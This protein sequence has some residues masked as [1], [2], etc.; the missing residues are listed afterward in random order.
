MVKLGRFIVVEGLEGAGKSTVVN[1]MMQYLKQH[2]IPTLSTR[3]PGG[4]KIGEALRQLIKHGLEGE[5]LV[6]RAELLL[7]YAARVQLVETTIR[8][9]L[10]QGTWIIAD[11]FEWS[12]YAYQGGGRRIDAQVIQTISQAALQGFE[13]DN[14]VYLDIAPEQGLMRAKA[15]GEIDLIEQESLDFFHRVAQ[16]YH[17]KIRNTQ[18]VTVLDAAQSLPWMRDQIEHLLQSLMHHHDVSHAR[19]ASE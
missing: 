5:T 9:S 3:E 18:Q 14:T 16:V 2:N 13:P 11:R 1:I 15:R 12:T 4:T 10:A 8:P 19:H 17:E 7:M 6:P